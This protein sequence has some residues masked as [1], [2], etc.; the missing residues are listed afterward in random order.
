MTPY[1]NRRTAAAFF[2]SERLGFIIL[3]TLG[4]S[5]IIQYSGSLRSLDQ[6]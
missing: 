5:V 3:H 1:D 4:A 6:V 2:E